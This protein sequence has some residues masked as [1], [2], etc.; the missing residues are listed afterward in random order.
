MLVINASHTQHII[1]VHSKA[2]NIALTAELGRLPIVSDCIS[3]ALKYYLRLQE[4]PLLS[5]TKQAYL[6]INKQLGPNTY[7]HLLRYL[8]TEC[9][10][11]NSKCI[12]S[13]GD[14]TKLG[15]NIIHTLFCKYRH[16]FSLKIQSQESKLAFY[17]T[18]KVNFIYETY[19]TQVNNPNHRKSLTRLRISAHNLPIERGRYKNIVYVLNVKQ[20]KL[21]LSNTH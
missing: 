18:F 19:L 8:S 20:T 7:N 5:L 3:I 1:G 4:L 9:N 15:Q 16:D 10:L 11:P 2:T 17:K 21:D 14:I 13:K 6:S 12:L